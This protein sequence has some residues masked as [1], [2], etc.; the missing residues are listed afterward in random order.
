MVAYHFAPD[1]ASGT[2]RAIHFAR[3]LHDA[4]VRVFVLTVPAEAAK[5]V[6]PKLTEVFP[7]PERVIR[8]AE[9]RTVGQAYLR[10]KRLLKPQHPRFPELPSAGSSADPV[11]AGRTPASPLDV[12]RRNLA[13]WDAFPDPQR[14]WYRSALRAGLRLGRREKITAVFA[15]GPP[16]TAV[17]VGS[18]LSRKLRCPLIADFRDPWTANTGCNVYRLEWCHRLA[19][20]W[21]KQV[22]G[23]ASLVLFNSPALMQ[24]ASRSYRDG[25]FPK[26]QTILNGSDAPRRRAASPIPDSEPIRIRHFG[27]LYGGRSVAPLIS[28]IRV[29]IGTGRVQPR[30]VSIE[31]FGP[32][33]A[34]VEEI[35]L[36]AQ[37]HGIGIRLVPKL[38]YADAMA[39]MMEPSVLLVVQPPRFDQQIPTKLYDYLCSGN[40]VLVMAAEHSAT[41]SVAR[42]YPRCQRF[43]HA[44]PA[45]TVR[46]LSGLFDAWQAGELRQ[47]RTVEDTAGLGKKALGERFLEA[48]V[49]VLGTA[50]RTLNRAPVC[51]VDSANDQP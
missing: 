30:K 35:E 42:L 47:E 48:V 27:T 9:S 33:T 3:S 12:L 24:T 44:D 50:P 41:W 51:V 20:R 36:T 40:P 17:R 26:F 32:R 22:F 10:I 25:E 46:V 45:E 39:R 4:G 38:A 11:T 15:S 16:W 21:E 13:A 34:E 49:Q 19:R 28:A 8:P 5:S 29:L 2:H 14:G 1:N 43:D 23:R 7:F 6:D 18:T 37:S 31:L